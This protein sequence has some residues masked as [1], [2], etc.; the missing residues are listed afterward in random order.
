MHR[1]DRFVPTSDI[2][3]LLCYERGR[4]LRRPY[5]AS[6]WSVMNLSRYLAKNTPPEKR[7]FLR[8]AAAVIITYTPGVFVIFLLF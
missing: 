2:A 7:A 6:E 3:G 4:K 8:A 1:N 5:N